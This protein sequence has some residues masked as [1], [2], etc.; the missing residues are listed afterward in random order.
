MDKNMIP[1]CC[2]TC[3]HY[4]KACRLRVKGWLGKD[5]DTYF[6]AKWDP[7]ET[8]EGENLDSKSD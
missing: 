4:E 8:I 3:R 5:H 1:V 2:R 7:K 6:C